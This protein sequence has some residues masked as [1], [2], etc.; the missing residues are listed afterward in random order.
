[1]KLK[2][3]TYIIAEVGN[4]HEGNFNVAKRL[5]VLAAKAGVDA[6]KFQTYKTENFIRKKDKKRF[7]T[8]KKF[9][10]SYKQFEILK[11][12]AHLNK[13]EFISTPLDLE[14]ADF[15][16][17]SADAI[18]IASGDNNFFPLI[19]K[20]LFSKKSLIISTGMTDIKNLKYLIKT[21]EKKIGKIRTKNKVFLLHC[22]TS[23]PVEDK[24]ANL[25]SISYLVKNFRLK[26]GYSDHT[27]GNEAC[28]ASVALGAKIIE[29]HFT[30]D[31][32]FSNFRDHALSADFSDLKN[33]VKSIR[34]IEKQLGEFNKK[35]EKP[36]KKIIK[37]VRRGVYA[38]MTIHKGK[39][40]SS[41]NSTFLR[42]SKN[43]EYLYIKKIVGKKIK[44]T[45][46]KNQIVF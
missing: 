37:A 27:I 38:K 34:K 44:N 8:L 9:E 10:L 41:V 25:K 24:Y 7:S 21:I 28:L 40:V 3:K 45:K 6:V 42:P 17:K 31:K 5:V 4:N 26:I 35:I 33:L 16:M 2:K 32:N 19:E 22:V 13:I 29:K 30:L 43:R 12:I 46:K 39:K 36:E 14:S 20:V 18:K 1:M 11:K 23:Y 15:L